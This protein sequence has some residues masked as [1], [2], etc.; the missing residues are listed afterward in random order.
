[1]IYHVFSFFRDEHFMA[2][3]VG[4]VIEGGVVEGGQGLAGVR[5]DGQLLGK[6][7]GFSAFGKTLNAR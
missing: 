3:Q 2:E 1:M 4:Q 5:Y 6:T 7:L